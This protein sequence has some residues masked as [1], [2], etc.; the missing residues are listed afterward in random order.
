MP[1]SSQCL[2]VVTAPPAP[3]SPW[4]QILTASQELKDTDLEHL[5]VRGWLA[6]GCSL[7]LC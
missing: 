4:L 3:C 7:S 5:E 2:L 6:W 1:G